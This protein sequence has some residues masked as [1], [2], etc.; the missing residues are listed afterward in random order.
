M[1]TSPSCIRRPCGTFEFQ[2]IR[3]PA[4]PSTNTGRL[5]REVGRFEV[6]TP[7]H[8][9]RHGVEL[10][11]DLRSRAKRGTFG[12]RIGEIYEGLIVEIRR[13]G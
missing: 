1:D 10:L 11:K 2:M 7:G 12:T 3:S 5:S 8:A 4:F 6:E 13:R 9:R